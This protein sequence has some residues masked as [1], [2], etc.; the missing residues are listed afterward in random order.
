MTSQSAL[1][2]SWDAPGV[3]WGPLGVLLASLGDLEGISWSTLG[4]S[5]YTL[6]VLLDPDVRSLFGQTVVCF[7]ICHSSFFVCFLGCSFG[8]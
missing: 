7:A 3:L 2:V 1:G 5:W 4:A 8:P 6:R